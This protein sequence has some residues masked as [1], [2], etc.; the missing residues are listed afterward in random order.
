MEVCHIA[1][2]QVYYCCALPYSCDI[3]CRSI[4]FFVRS[5]P[6]FFGPYL[7][8]IGVHKLAILELTLWM[9]GVWSVPGRYA[10]GIISNLHTM[11][12]RGW[13]DCQL[14]MGKTHHFGSHPAS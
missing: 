9:L 14:E 13:K 1:R 4:S 11:P 3:Y 12:L 7:E 2:P 5:G 10:V 6:A 8:A